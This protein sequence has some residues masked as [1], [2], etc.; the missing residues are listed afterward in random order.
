M[1]EAL[2]ARCAVR[3]GA[4][5]TRP[6]SQDQNAAEFGLADARRVFQHRLEHRLQLAGRARADDLAAPRWSRSAAPA[7]RSARAVRW[8]SSL[9]SRTFSMAITA[10]AAKVVTSSICLSVNGRTSWRDRCRLR[11]SPRPRGA[12]GTPSKVREPPMRA[13]RRAGYLRCGSGSAAHR[14]RGP[15]A[16]R[17]RR[18][19]VSS[20]P[21]TEAQTAGPAGDLGYLVSAAVRK[22]TRRATMHASPSQ[23][24]IGAEPRLAQCAVAF[25]QHR[26]RTPVADRWASG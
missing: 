22:R 1:R 21:H 10:W 14:R 6:S 23:E 3:G 26:H 12:S 24:K 8:R 7:T 25:L 5:G 2:A 9:N 15:P 13:P 4:D 18:D 19:G 11:R 17:D 20:G 16:G